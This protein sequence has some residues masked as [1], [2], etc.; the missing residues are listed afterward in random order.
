MTATAPATPTPIR[1]TE[2]VA[3]PEATSTV[4]TVS[5]GG[6][7]E[8]LPK[9]RGTALKPVR[10]YPFGISRN[11]LEQAIS[12]F[13]VAAA[14]TRDLRE[15][16]V[17]LTLKNYYRRRPQQLQE[18]EAIGKPVYVM[19]SNTS[20]QME[21]VLANIFGRP[22]DAGTRQGSTGGAHASSDQDDSEADTEDLEGE[23]QDGVTHALY[24]AEIAAEVVIE[25]ARA[26]ELSPQVSYVRRLQHKVAERYNLASRS[27]GK[28]PQRRVEILPGGKK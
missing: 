23:N 6:I 11:R 1:P 22:V 21:A 15:A 10:L 12:A 8:Q 14:I 17:A 4:S 20:T 2:A 28:E 16:D 25:S 18:A 13:G 24:E 26:V 7:V 3:P 19:R 27:R 9:G 5:T